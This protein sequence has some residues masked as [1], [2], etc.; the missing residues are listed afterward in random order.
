MNYRKSL[1]SMFLLALVLGTTSPVFVSASETTTQSATVAE[2]ATTTASTTTEASTGLPVDTTEL[3]ES[4]HTLN[5]ITSTTENTTTTEETTEEKK[6]TSDDSEI[7]AL[8]EAGVLEGIIGSDGQYRVRNTTVNPYRKTGIISVTYPNGKRGYGTGVMIAPNLVL[9]AAHV[10]YSAEDGGWAKATTVTPAFDG[11]T[12]HYGTYSAQNIYMFRHYKT[13]TDALAEDNDMAVIRLTRNVDSR[14]GYLAVS[15]SQTTGERIQLPGYPMR[16]DAKVGYMYTMFD[17]ISAISGKNIRYLLDTEP[18]QSGGGVLNRNN[19]IIAVNTYEYG[20]YNRY[21]GEWIE[22]HYNQARRIMGDSMTMINMAKRNLPGNL[23]VVSQKTAD[24]KYVTYRLYHSGIQRHLYTQSLD[25]ASVLITRGWNFEGQKFTTVASGTPVY[26][27][28]GKV[29]REHL[30]TTSKHERD[31]L[32]K[33]GAWNGEGIAFYSG[34][35]TPVYRLYHDGLRVHLY[36]ADKNE[37]KVLGTRGWR[38]EGVAF[39]TK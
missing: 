29:M 16:T 18:G 37:V 3:T 39:Y 20:T 5:V 4:T 34:G 9:T 10:V 11:K 1:C 33:T 28:Y 14:V 2:E 24:P 27:L 12:A 36:T 35:K 7:A 32:V 13:T 26:R 38:N 6:S 22:F 21:T 15:T 19:Q 25:E 31:T 8:E 30:Y 17:K 23:S